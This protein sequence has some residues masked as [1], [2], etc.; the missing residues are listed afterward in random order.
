MM[1]IPRAHEQSC[2][3]STGD[4]LL[5]LDGHRDRWDR[6]PPGHTSP[7]PHTEQPGREKEVLLSS[8]AESGGHTQWSSD[9]DRG[10][11]TVP[12]GH[13]VSA[14]EGLAQK[15]LAGQSMGTSP[16]HGPGQVVPIGQAV[17]LLDV[18]FR[19]VPEGHMQPMADVV[20]SCSVAAVD[21]PPST[22]LHHLG[23][24]DCGGQ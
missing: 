9:V 10:G 6:R 24:L 17:H 4:V 11:D 22:S 19:V 16:L 18:A 13:R 7:A 8:S 3:T 20:P 2:C 1:C 21:S 14:R 12:S 5:P 15:E 23:A